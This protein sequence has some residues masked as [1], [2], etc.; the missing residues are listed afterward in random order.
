MAVVGYVGQ[1]HIGENDYLVGSTLFTVLDT[2]S[3]PASG[4]I[5]NPDNNTIRFNVP[6]S[7]FSLARGVTVHV[8]FKQANTVINKTLQLKVGDADPKE[9]K[10]P[11]GAKSWK[12][13]TVISFTYDGT[14]WIMNSSAIDASSVQNLSLGNIDNEG[15]LGVASSL[16]VT[17]A[18]KEITTGAAFTSAISSQSQS[19]T[20]L[21]SD[22]TWAAPSYTTA[23]THPTDAGNKHIPSGGSSGQFLKYGNSSGTAVWAT[24][25]V[26]DISD[27]PS[28]MTP[29]SHTHGNITNDGA[30]QTTDVTIADGDKLVI[31]D[32]SNSDKI[33]RASIAFDGTTATKALTQ[34]GTWETFNNYTHPTTD[35]NK[36]V[37]ANGTT[38]G[39]KFLKATST[40]GS[41][42]WSDLSTSDV[43]LDNV[44]NHA[45]VTSLQWNTSG[46]KITYKVSEGTATDL[47]TFEQGSNITLTAAAGKLTIAGTANNAVTQTNTTDNNDY[48]LLFSYSTVTT[49]TKT[50]GA[51]KHSTLKYNPSTGTLTATKFSG[52]GSGLTG[53]TASSIAWDNITGTPTTL[54]GY[55]ITDALSTSSTITIAGN[56]VSLN[57]GSL[58]ASTLRTSL[59]LASALRF[60]GTTTSNISDGW[61]GVPAGIT[62][63]T[64]PQVGDV[65]IKG[66]A[67]YVCISVS[68]TTYTWE[69]LGRDSS[70]ALDSDVVKKSIFTAAYQIVYSTGAN[71]PVVLDANTTATKKFLRM[72]GTGA[73]GAAPEWDTVTKTDVGLSNVENTK[74]STWTGSTYI[75]T[76]GTITSGTWNGTA[77]AADYIG[78]HSTA[79]LT[80][81]TLGTARGG[82][83]INS[84]TKG[85][86]LYASADNVLSK[87]NAGTDGQVL[88][89]ASGVPSWAA[90][91]ATDENVKQSPV[92]YN[93]TNANKEYAVLFKN[94]HSAWTEE[95]A[96]VKFAS[97]DT[98]RITINPST[99]TLTAKNLVG[100]LRAADVKTAL[101]YNS[102]STAKKFLHES[103]AWKTVSVSVD[104]ND[105]G[106]VITSVSH[107]GGSFPSLGTSGKA[108][109]FTVNAG[110]L[111]I[112]AGSDAT[113]SGGSFPTVTT[114]KAN[115]SIAYS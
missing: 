101:G 4:S 73:A 103:G 31:T 108:A 10:N 84:Y 62:N 109:T 107:S 27:F 81:G 29:S 38:N 55:G 91:Q 78:N 65:V 60:V 115:L 53:V 13:D 23:Y 26:S 83:G 89:L 111:T 57:G 79:K 90:N 14:S 28:T 112:T 63:Y 51:R 110:V 17:N 56:S 2:S 42:E 95:T 82:T 85:D 22:G 39:G 20:F 18:S 54:S 70:F 47:L 97:S 50:E 45:Q 35:G 52:D 24:L 102:S 40:A 64:T 37:P 66:D 87:L 32:N 43:G 104:A 21:R 48:S 96:G 69:L 77:I 74:L 6:L 19:T 93:G 94:T 88:T 15:K 67:E 8:Q 49:D 100:A 59:G 92:A 1:I 41:Y 86:I 75:A 105:S 46:K 72:T 76:V 5:T 12:A 68:G 71:S 30:L 11:N 3:N 106:S 25:A 34:K 80:S 98:Y 114:T 7:N 36:H 99:G 44:T 58:S 61:T 16:V 113:L 33:A 9:I